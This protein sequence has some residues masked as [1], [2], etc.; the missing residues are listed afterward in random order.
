LLGEEARRVVEAAESFA[1]GRTHYRELEHLARMSPRDPAVIPPRRGLRHEERKFRARA[2]ATTLAA[3][4]ARAA[5]A[6]DGHVAASAVQGALT[7]AVKRW[8]GDPGGP[9]RAMSRDRRARAELLRDVVGNPYRPVNIPAAWL[10]WEGGIVVGLARGA[11]EK[12]ELPSGRLDAGRLAIL[13]DALEEAGCDDHILLGHLRGP[14][15]HVRG[16][17]AVEA[18][19]AKA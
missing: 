16:C 19:G 3:L 18:L 8:H 12:R 6:S 5:A 17:W 2:W 11:Y 9:V 14:G 15:P 1:D 7:M 13:A 4:A 10:A